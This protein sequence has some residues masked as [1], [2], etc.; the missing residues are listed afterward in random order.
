M[1]KLALII[2]VLVAGT[3]LFTACGNAQSG[4]QTSAAD[5]TEAETE[6]VETTGAET[7]A[8]APS[9][10]VIT[11]GWAVNLD[12]EP[13]LSDEEAA[14][15]AAAAEKNPDI[16]FEPITVIA[17]QLVSGINYDYLCKDTASASW[18]IVTVYENLDGEAEAIGVYDLDPDNITTTGAPY[19]ASAGAWAATDPATQTLALTD[20]DAQTAF[21]KATENVDQFDYYP[22]A[23]LSTQV[24]AGLNYKVLCYGVAQSEDMDIALYALTIYAD[25]EGNAN[26]EKAEELDIK[27]YAGGNF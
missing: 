5:A 25:L 23:V 4:G 3:V 11:G 24:V 6:D 10:E 19:E 13:N 14:R 27:A 22:I 26:I 2:S 20:A 16:A 15:F 17:S 1:K 18:K 8:E 21:E 12:Q 9:E 7:I